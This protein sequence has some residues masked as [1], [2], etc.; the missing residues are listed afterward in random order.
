M[1]NNDIRKILQ[2]SEERSSA[3]TEPAGMLFD[4]DPETIRSVDR[5]LLDNR[6]KIHPP[7]RLRTCVRLGLV[8]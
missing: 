8:R 3:P 4:R 7:W 1:T 6:I 2:R 5:Q